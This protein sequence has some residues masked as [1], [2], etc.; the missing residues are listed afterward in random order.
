[1][2]KSGSIQMRSGPLSPQLLASMGHVHDLYCFFKLQ[3]G[4]WT[5]FV[6]KSTQQRTCT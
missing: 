2:K 4:Y 6:S 5:L 1:M 3:P